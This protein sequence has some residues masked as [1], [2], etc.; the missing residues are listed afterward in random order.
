MRL[1]IVS[2]VCC[3]VVAKLAAGQACRSAVC[4]T[5]LIP[6]NCCVGRHRWWHS[7][8]ETHGLFPTVLILILTWLSAVHTSFV[9][10]SPLSRQGH[11]FAEQDIGTMTSDSNTYELLPSHPDTPLPV[12]IQRSYFSHTLRIKYSRI[13]SRRRSKVIL[14]FIIFFCILLLCLLYWFRNLKVPPLYEEYHKKELSMPQHNPDLPMPEGD[15]GK[16][17]WVS[18]HL[19]GD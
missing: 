18:T 15:H 9:A 2:L 1:N 17:L 13:L 4:Y 12:A 19:D 8:E 7:F 3:G 5:T 6:R 16:Y 14:A 10:C 11:Q